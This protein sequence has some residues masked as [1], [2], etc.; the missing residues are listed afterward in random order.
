[1]ASGFVTAIPWASSVGTEAMAPLA[2][3]PA[4]P[5]PT[6]STATTAS[7]D[8]AVLGRSQVR[9]LGGAELDVVGVDAG[10]G[11]DVEAVALESER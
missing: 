5:S 3:L 4:G 8:D 6:A 10:E 1:M 2:T 9:G 7:T 11:G